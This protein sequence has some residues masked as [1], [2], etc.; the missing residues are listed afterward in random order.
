MRR[1]IADED[2]AG[3][4]IDKDQQEIAHDSLRRNHTLREKVTG[5]ERLGVYLDELFP[6][7][8]GAFRRGIDAL[9]FEDVVDRLPADAVGAEVTRMR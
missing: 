4:D 2:L 7:A 3:L 5:P 9:H 6:R 8:L 1:G